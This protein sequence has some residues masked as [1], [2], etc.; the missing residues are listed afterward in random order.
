MIPAGGTLFK[1]TLEE[2]QRLLA[3]LAS[4][5]NTSI[6]PDDKGLLSRSLDAIKNPFK[7]D[8]ICHT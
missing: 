7:K 3:A 8:F 5:I 6:E 4:T 1:G 2:C